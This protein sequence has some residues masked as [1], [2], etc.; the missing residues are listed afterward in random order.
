MNTTAEVAPFLP[1]L[2]RYARA[3]SGS[4][5]RGDAYVRALLE[6]VL[7]GNVSLPNGIGARVALYQLFHSFWSAT[8]P[9]MAEGGA[10]G[11]APV[12]MRLQTLQPGRREALLLVAME[13][14]FVH[15]AAVILNVSEDE[16]QQAI[17]SALHAID[18]DLSSRIL[19][20]EDEAVIAMDLEN[21]VEESGHTVVGTAR[22]RK[23]AIRLAAE[24]KPDLVLA[25]VQLAD[26]SSG[27]D[28]AG[29]I[30]KSSNIPVIFITAFPECLLTGERRE[31]TYL[32]SKPFS[33]ETVKAT[34][35]QALFLHKPSTE[36][37]EKDASQPEDMRN[38]ACH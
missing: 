6:N 34:I 26:G 20:I 11:L 15:E 35:N 19:I 13:G 14:F 4:Q 33:H 16:V 36:G 17:A 32:L 21:L 9:H 37:G 18:S 10:S 25:D 31:P 2:R 38:T 22:T 12:E 30:L 23:E 5:S 1:F 29:E 8:G 7:E 24:H 27:I 28:A 3:L